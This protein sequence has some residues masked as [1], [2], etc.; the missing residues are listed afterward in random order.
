[1]DNLGEAQSVN[2]GIWTQPHGT[3]P[4]ITTSL[5]RMLSLLSKHNIKATYFIESWSLS[6]YPSIVQQLISAGHE[7]AW[8]AYQHEVWHV[9]TETEEKQNFEK[10]FAAAAEAGVIYKGFRPPGG[11][12]NERTWELLKEHGVG[13]ASPLGKF[14]VEDGTVVLPFEW[15]GVDAFYY[16]DKF[17]GIRKEEGE[18]GSAMTPREFEEFLLRRIEQTKR[19]GG[20]LSVLFHP[21]LTTDDERFGVMDEVVRKLSEDGEIWCAPCGQV[22]EWVREHEGEFGFEKE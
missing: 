17:E 3:H 7:V 6:V 5:P 9:Q 18:K 2:R 13:Y 4:S 11:R 12:L 21:F 19:E 16:M 15:R 1:M 22:A 14:G 10:S 20:Y 8:H